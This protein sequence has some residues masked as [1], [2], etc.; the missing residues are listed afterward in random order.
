MKLKEAIEKG[1]I[2][3]DQE[4]EVDIAAEVCNKYFRD[5]H[6]KDYRESAILELIK[7]NVPFAS[8]FNIVYE[9]YKKF[10]IVKCP[11]CSFQM[12]LVQGGGSGDRHTMYYECET[13]QS[14]VTLSTDSNGMG[15]TPNSE[16]R[17]PPLKH[18]EVEK[19][20][21]IYTLDQFRESVKSCAF[22]DDDG[23]GQY[24]NGKIKWGRVYPSD[25]DDSDEW[26]RQLKYA[27][28][29]VWYNK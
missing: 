5:D 13:C 23:H 12:E 7:K 27:T 17:F 18:R 14:K 16:L 4:I 11:T 20:D 29:I 22:L 2:N 26:N 15:V 1:L 28:H 8:N 6:C 9:L 3:P 19:D 10:V 24:S 21:D 25:V